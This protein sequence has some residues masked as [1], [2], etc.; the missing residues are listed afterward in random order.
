MPTFKQTL[1]YLEPG[2][3]LA[4]SIV[5]DK[6]GRKSSSFTLMPQRNR[7]MMNNKT[8]TLI[9][10][11]LC[12][13]SLTTHLLV[14]W[15]NQVWTWPE[16][17]E[18]APWYHVSLASAETKIND[19]AKPLF[20]FHLGP[21]RQKIM[22]T[23]QLAAA[24]YNE[25][26]MKDGIYYW[27]YKEQKT[28]ASFLDDESVP[29]LRSLIYGNYDDQ[30]D[31]ALCDKN[32]HTLVE[33]LEGKRLRNQTIFLSDESV[34]A[35]I[36]APTTDKR[37]ELAQRFLDY[38]ASH[39]NVR[40]ILTYQ[41]H[42]KT[43]VEN[44]MQSCETKLNSWKTVWPNET[45]KCVLPSFVEY[46]KQHEKPN[47]LTPKKRKQF[48]SLK[49]LQNLTLVVKHTKEMLTSNVKIFN[50]HKY[51]SRQANDIFHEF[52]CEMIPEART[53]CH[54]WSTMAK[55]MT[56]IA[57]PERAEQ[58][59]DL[60]LFIFY[61]RLITTAYQWGWIPSETTTIT[62]NQLGQLLQ[63]ILKFPIQALERRSANNFPTQCLAIHQHK[64]MWDQTM[65][66]ESNI[67]PSLP[68]A[69]GSY[70][71]VQS[72]K[73]RPEFCSIDV[74]QIL[75]M[76]SDL[77]K[78]F[79]S[80]LPDSAG[81]PLPIEIRDR[82]QRT[83][84]DSYWS[85]KLHLPTQLLEVHQR[86]SKTRTP[87]S[88]EAGDQIRRRTMAPYVLASHKLVFFSTPKVGCT[89]WKIMFRR[90][91]GYADWDSRDPHSLATS[92]LPVLSQYSLE[93]A[94]EMMNSPEW[95]RAIFLR[96]PK[97]RF[98]SA[99]LDKA[100]G[101][102]N[103]TSQTREMR[104]R[105]P[106]D[107]EHFFNTSRTL[108]DFLSLTESCQDDHWQPQ[109]ER[110]EEKYWGTID[111]VGNIE[112]GDVDAKRLLQRIGAW[113]QYGATGWGEYHNASFFTKGIEPRAN[114][115]H[116]T[117]AAGRLAKYYTPEIDALVEQRY[118]NDY[119]FFGFE[120]VNVSLY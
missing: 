43:I 1:A 56:P 113:D 105:C 83:I 21:S 5:R 44:Y 75:T 26:L 100:L 99:Y 22:T 24:T 12:V 94:T 111:F 2:T 87:V 50:V 8:L 106:D 45:V 41:R 11:L 95:T 96:D 19:D 34:L 112:T 6:T 27:G 14:D 85:P 31:P 78:D 29:K 62:R 91:M 17:L 15:G 81:G 38:L 117:G 108:L 59:M 65:K 84:N 119:M 3:K 72:L 101:E 40:A 25:T 39:W 120:R 18:T 51:T 49:R 115:T 32:F 71:G 77:W 16:S 66:I 30:E 13:S 53:L 9:I 52:I 79:F 54:E 20:V 88:V 97:E 55:P 69:S 86:L 37:F 33:F 102:N 76:H 68:K 58:Q 46:F 107:A 67:F 48:L 35:T 82:L 103:S 23:I 60:P 80:K 42:H 114:H 89:A 104:R 64:Y 90:M 61:D 116:K 7:K 57:P 118:A 110:V 36:I 109:I 73:E 70:A 92:G 93:Q 63:R 98:L 47:A 28:I 10:P 74:D 4:N